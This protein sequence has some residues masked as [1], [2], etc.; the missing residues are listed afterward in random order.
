[1]W[2]RL[3]FALALL[4]AMLLGCASSQPITTTSWLQRFRPNQGAAGKDVVQIDVALAQT[5]AGDAYLDRDLWTVADEQVIPME[6]KAVLED[7]G[8]RVGVLGSLPP[9]GLQMLLAS[10]RSCIKPQRVQVRAGVAENVTL[11]ASL[12]LSRFEL[13]LDGKKQPQTLEQAEYHL[14]ITPTLEKDGRITLHFLPQSLHGGRVLI[15]RPTPDHSGWEQG[16]LGDDYS[17]L[18]WDLTL[19]DNDF[20]LVGTRFSRRGTLGTE[21][22]LRLEARPPSQRVLVLHVSRLEASVDTAATEEA[23]ST[24]RAPPLAL[25]ARW[26]CARGSTP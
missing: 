2:P 16:P 11:C 24:S 13:R 1:M 25:Q 4:T 6:E 7:N 17:A 5:L 22:F 3:G 14:K 26:S 19:A 18:A 20:A 9:P 15:P 21:C 12:P 8:F 10:Q 23:I